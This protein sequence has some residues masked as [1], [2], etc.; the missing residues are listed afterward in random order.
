MNPRI[1]KNLKIL[2]Y[3]SFAAMPMGSFS[4][5]ALDSIFARGKVTGVQIVAHSN[6]KTHAYNYG[7]SNADEAGK[8]N[9]STVFQAASLGKVVL[10]YIVLKMVDRK[11]ISLDT[12][13]WNYYQYDRIKADTAAQKITARMV[14]H[15]QT[16]FPN[17]VLNPTAKQWFRSPLKTSFVPGSSWSYSGEGFM[18]LQYAVES[19]WKQSLEKI[20][21]QEVFIPLQM[22]SSSFLWQRSFDTSGAYGHNK[23]GD[24]TARNEPFFTAAAY[25]LLTTASDY[26]NFLHAL[27]TGNGLSETTRQ[28]MISDTVSIS[29]NNI[30]RS[31]AAS[32]ISW[33]LGVG[34]QR[35]TP[36]TAIWHWGD[37]GDFKCFF[38]AFP[39]KNNS[40]VYFTNSENGLNVMPEVL[41]YYFGTQTWW[42]LQ[43]M[44][45]DF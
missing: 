39:E 16:G 31:E 27:A 35:N 18:Y 44:D 10:A 32:H 43:W 22:T 4:Q 20:A 40:I 12:P 6:N 36:G 17:W 9:G 15:H 5:P 33:G 42:A 41:N 45:K 13:L 34:I 21:Q 30:P 1:N 7:K 3:L 28:L 25:S 19:I 23:D 2:F 37:N 11:M 38:M 8:V 26:H 29:K 14:L 24:V